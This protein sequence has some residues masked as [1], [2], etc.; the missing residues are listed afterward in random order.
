MYNFFKMIYDL[1]STPISM[2]NFNLPFNTIEI[3]IKLVL[4][5]VISLIIYKLLLKWIRSIIYKSKINDVKKDQVFFAFRLVFRIVLIIIISLLLINLLGTQ[6]NIYIAS[7]GKVLTHPIVEDISIVTILLILPILYFSQVL[8]RFTQKVTQKSLLPYIKL[9]SSTKHTLTAVIKNVTVAF[10]IVFGLTVI[11]I[12]LSLLFGLFGVV[13]IGLGFGLQ[14]VVANLFSGIV[15]LTTRPVKIGDHITV[16]GTEGNLEEI[17]FLSSVVSTVTH[18]SIIIPNSKLIENPVYNFSFDDKSIIIK[19]SVQVSYE[20][21]LDEV[22][23][24]LKRVIEKCPYRLKGKDVKTR[25]LSFDDS[26]ISIGTVC[27][28]EDSTHKYDAHSWVNLEIWRAFKE[29]G[30]EIPYP[31]L[32]VNVLKKN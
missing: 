6:I 31:K 12:D 3:L 9:D 17:R 2:G 13:G 26:G 14:G 10:A 29:V 19:N 1:L 23:D 24:L 28:I 27:W 8:G 32:D 11:G 16:D 18:E 30:I 25:V 7:M 5:I 15:I 20:S 22:L 4:P 21:N